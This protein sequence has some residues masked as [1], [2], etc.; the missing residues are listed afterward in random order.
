[1]VFILA[2]IAATM[3]RTPVVIV[4]GSM[5]ACR[6][7]DFFVVSEPCVHTSGY[8]QR[9]IYPLLARSLIQVSSMVGTALG[10]FEHDVVL[11]GA[12]REDGE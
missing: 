5:D 9:K 10:L 12:G 2:D 3:V 7:R 1:M 6:W 4:N 11:S 8:S